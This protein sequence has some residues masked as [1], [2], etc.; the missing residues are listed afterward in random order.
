[1]AFDAAQKARRKDWIQHK[2]Q[3]CI[4]A[5]PSVGSDI[6]AISNLMLDC[7]LDHIDE[8]VDDT[9]TET[10]IT[11]REALNKADEITRLE[12]ELTKLKGR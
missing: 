9:Q 12:A 3:E 6:V 4:A 5:D 2:L 1:M 7:I 10:Y 8:F 11:D